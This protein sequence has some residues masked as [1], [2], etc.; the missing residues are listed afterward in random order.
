[1]R[2]LYPDHIFYSVPVKI[3]LLKFYSFAY[4]ITLYVLFER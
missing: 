3:C 2:F 1:M 4:R